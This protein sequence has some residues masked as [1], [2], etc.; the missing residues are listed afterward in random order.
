MT[1]TAN[2]RGSTAHAQPSATTTVTAA[3]GME[4]GADITG[5]R[6]TGI[7]GITGAYVTRGP[8]D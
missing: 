5:A 8:V 7:T 4:V 6:V 2:G 3:V 1:S